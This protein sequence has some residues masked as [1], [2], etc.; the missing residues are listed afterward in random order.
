MA[1]VIY[2]HNNR[3]TTII[4]ILKYPPSGDGGVT[5]HP[6]LS[7]RDAADQ[8]PINAITPPITALDTLPA[9]TAY[10]PIFTTA[11]F[12]FTWAK[13]KEWLDTIYGKLFI[14]FG[15]TIIAAGTIEA[16]DVGKMVKFNSASNLDQ[17]V[18]TAMPVGS[19]VE[20]KIEGAG[21]PNFTVAAGQAIAAHTITGR[22]NVMLRRL[23][24]ISN[25]QQF[26]V[27]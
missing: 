27:L 6:L 24:D 9:D 21:L 22:K 10:F 25:V 18:G 20:F 23:E 12:R 2:I 7:N 14:Q 3:P 5:S 16:A 11:W 19:F 1:K 15:R 8:H 4:N 17:A 26:D 13:L